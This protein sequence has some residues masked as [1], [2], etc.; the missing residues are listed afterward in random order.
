MGIRPV[1]ED[2]LQSIVTFLTQ[3]YPKLQRDRP[4]AERF[5][6][7]KYFDLVGRETGYPPA[8]WAE[9]EQ[10]VAGFIGCMPF[11]LVHQQHAYPAGWIADWRLA[12]RVRGQGVG[13]HLLHT[14]IDTVPTVCCINGSEEAQRVY[15]KVGFQAWDCGHSWIRV[16]RPL[17]YSL[18][19]LHAGKKLLALRPLVK[20]F[21]NRKRIPA[22]EAISVGEAVD[23]GKAEA[24]LAT[25]PDGLQRDQHYF[26]WLRRC[27]VGEINFHPLQIDQKPLGYTLLL[28]GQDDYGRRVGR[29]VDFYVNETP[30]VPEAYAAVIHYMQT[31]L[32]PF[33]YLETIS[34]VS[35][36]KW[37]GFTAKNGRRFW[38]KTNV[39]HPEDTVEWMVSLVDKDNTSRKLYLVP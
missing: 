37:L 2:D 7:W 30:C 33:D 20:H 11:F 22:F 1:V 31:A 17:A 21:L 10:G 36:L 26:R 39:F 3:S 13:Q 9:D 4:F 24:Y 25:T 6:R 16:M 28:S 29:I 34:P 18:P 35:T 23:P 19:T 12:D 14:A 38:L 32:P 27:P 8:F 15:H 5:Y